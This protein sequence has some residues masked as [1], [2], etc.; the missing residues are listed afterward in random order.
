MRTAHCIHCL[1]HRLLPAPDQV[2]PQSSASGADQTACLSGQYSV[3]RAGGGRGRAWVIAGSCCHRTRERHLTFPRQLLP[4]AG[5][6]PAGPPL[7]KHLPKF[8]MVMGKRVKSCPRQPPRVAASQTE[9]QS[10]DLAGSR[11]HSILGAEAGLNSDFPFLIGA[12]SILTEVLLETTRPETSGAM[13]LHF[14]P[15]GHPGP[16]H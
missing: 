2:A 5:E 7:L 9:T 10:G 15:A 4:S 13:G 8:L 3:I 1:L 14:F 16:T 12:F 6:E 11:S